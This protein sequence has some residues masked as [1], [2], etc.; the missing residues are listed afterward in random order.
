MWYLK[1]IVLLVVGGSFIFSGCASTPP[2]T[3]KTPI[4]D[5]NAPCWVIKGGA[6]F[7]GD[8]G[9]AIYGIA[10]AQGIRNFSL[11][12]ITADN[13]ARTAIS[14]NIEVYI[15][16]LCKDYIAST[17][18]GEPNVSSEEQHVECAKKAVTAMNLAGSEVIDHW[19]N[20]KTGE[21]F[22]LA[23][24]DLSGFKDT[25][26]KIKQL[27]SKLKEYIKENADSLHKKLEK[28]EKIN[29]GRQ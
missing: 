10:S 13:R 27:D 4:Q 12:R 18:A 28:E 6:C 23:R 15:A 19:Q 16:S 8:K 7:G 1:K 14:R 25:A 29:Q 21:F 22:A 3:A 20:P 11:L 5:L 2:I 17:T 9:R 24:V 26:E